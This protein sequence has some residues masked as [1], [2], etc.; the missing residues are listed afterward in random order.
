MLKLRRAKIGNYIYNA[1]WLSSPKS[2]ITWAGKQLA[3][4][5][6]VTEQLKA[7][8]P[9]MWIQRM[10]N[11]QSRAREIVNNELIYS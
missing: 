11:I 9:M 5:E 2:H 8:K 4:K 3:E 7:E 10:N 1:G 6:G